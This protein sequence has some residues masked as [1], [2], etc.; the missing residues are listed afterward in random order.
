M[1]EAFLRVRRSSRI[2]TGIKPLVG[3]EVDNLVIIRVLTT[4]FQIIQFIV[5]EKVYYLET[6]SRLKLSSI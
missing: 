5:R 6:H 3:S 4:V 1:D 2:Y